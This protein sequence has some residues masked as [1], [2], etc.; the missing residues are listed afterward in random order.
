MNFADFVESD[1]SE[2]ICGELVGKNRQNVLSLANRGAGVQ[3]R[4]ILAPWQSGDCGGLL[5]CRFLLRA[6]PAQME[7]VLARC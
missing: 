1:S 3:P 7:T 2:G 5:R 4:R 6:R